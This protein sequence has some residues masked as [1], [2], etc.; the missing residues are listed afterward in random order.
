MFGNLQ[1]GINH[2]TR[3]DVPLTTT[4]AML[5]TLA[6]VF[7]ILYRRRRT[8]SQQR[9]LQMRKDMSRATMAANELGK[10]VC[11][12]RNSTAK[13]YSRLKK[14]EKRIA[15][16]CVRQGDANWQELCREV[17]GILDPTL[18]LVSEIANAQ[19]RIRYQSNY[20]MTFSEMRT[21]PLTGLGNRRALDHVLATQFNILKRYGTPFSLAIVDIDH[22][23]DLNDQYGHQ[24]GDQVLCEFAQLLLGSLRIVDIVARFGGDEFVV[25]MPHTD[26]AE[27]ELVGERLRSEVERRMPFAISGGVAS[28]SDADTPESLFKRADDALYCAKTS[29]RNRILA[30]ARETGEPASHEAATVVC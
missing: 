10:V 2:F 23:K 6:Y 30:D 12:V 27:A 28:A 22:F 29:G 16:L 24:H 14:F 18:Q 20:L 11:L 17:E 19:E 8:A 5:V 9:L 3:I 7:G 25:M 4:L 21:D 1:M 26:I 13:H 15:R